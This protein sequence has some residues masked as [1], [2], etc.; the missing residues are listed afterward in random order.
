MDFLTAT[1]DNLNLRCHGHQKDNYLFLLVLFLA[2]SFL[3]TSSVSMQGGGGVILWRMVGVQ[4]AAALTHQICTRI[5]A[6]VHKSM[7]KIACTLA[8][9]VSHH[10]LTQN[11]KQQEQ[12]PHA[13]QIPASLTHNGYPVKVSTL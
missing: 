4:T 1:E 9:P 12:P 3:R 7:C 6:K 13:T 11:C 8:S 10:Y 2:R 5:T